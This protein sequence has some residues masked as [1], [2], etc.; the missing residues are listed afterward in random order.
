MGS[1]D[2]NEEVT[3]IQ[4]GVEN[5]LKDF[6]LEVEKENP[7]LK[8]TLI[9]SGSFYEGT[10]VCQP[11]EF[12]YFVQLDNFS[13]PTDI[14][15]DELPGST[16]IVIPSKSSFDKLREL[17]TYAK[18]PYHISVFDWKTHVKAP[19]VE[20]L[21]KKAEGFV[22]YGLRVIQTMCRHGPAYSLTLQWTGGERYRGLIISVDLSLAVKINSRSSTMK[23]DFG[24]PADDALKSI[25]DSL[26]Y[27][28]A[29]SDY[30]SL[31][32]SYGGPPSNMLKELKDSFNLGTQ[33]RFRLR[34]SQSCLEQALFRSFGP[35]GGPTVCLRA[36]KVLRDMS[37]IVDFDSMRSLLDVGS[38]FLR[39][40]RFTDRK[41]EYNKWLSSYA[42]KTLVL[43]EWRKY[44]EY[45][46]W[47]G[48]SL[49][50][51]LLN[52]LDTHLLCLKR[53]GLQ[54]FFYKDYNVF[55]EE[56]NKEDDPLWT[57]A[58][59]TIT[60]LHH[61]MMS[62][63]NAVNYSFNDCLQNITE[64]SILASNKMKFTNFLQITLDKNCRQKIDE[65]VAKA[66]AEEPSLLAEFFPPSYLCG[67]IP[68]P[69]F[70]SHLFSY[71]YIQALLDKVA[72]EEK[73]I[74][75]CPQ[76]CHERETFLI[77]ALDLFKDIA[78][79]RMNTLENNLPSYNIWTKEFKSG[80]REI[81]NL[82]EFLTDIF[83]TDLQ[84]LLNEL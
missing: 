36:L 22:G 32:K 23:P 16:V 15:F 29:V 46:Y 78:G 75:L 1:G 57:S 53:G 20:I 37:L 18:V 80:N 56:G 76:R 81:A 24:I 27:F 45:E 54:G 19:F 33:Y 34:C 26:T 82:V 5:V 72:P 38:S 67:Y 61:W 58:I 63:R 83:R 10:K 39:T 8:T 71:I 62:K 40:C 44:P 60:I 9:N 77:K 13:E 50:D 30:K 35:E 74:L 14:Q 3:D 65:V 21:D 43:F 59:N 51:R 2:E 42:L 28:F 70:D 73:L 64:E 66:M 17:S 55:H 4:T 68:S 84:L 79:T 49:S 41:D 47:S 52:I 48:S 12:D 25:S 6:L 7:F 31:Y 69:V 11:D